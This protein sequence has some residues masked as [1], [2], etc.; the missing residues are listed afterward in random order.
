MVVNVQTT[1]T[2]RQS[3]SDRQDGNGAQHDVQHWQPAVAISEATP[4]VGARDPTKHEGGRHV[5]GVVPYFIFRGV[6]GRIRRH[7]HWCY[8]NKLP[9][10]MLDSAMISTTS[11]SGR[12]RS[13][14]PAEPIFLLRFRTTEPKQIMQIPDTRYSSN[15]SAF[16]LML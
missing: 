9:G 13:L 6:G 14:L 4:K 15:A 2:G 16:R 1:A 5:A 8:I 11:A 10:E 7:N 12:G 3:K